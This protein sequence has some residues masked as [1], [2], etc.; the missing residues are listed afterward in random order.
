MGAEQATKSYEKLRS[1]ETARSPSASNP[2]EAPEW[3]GLVDRLRRGQRVTI[4]LPR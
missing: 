4:P 3:A 1:F 2:P